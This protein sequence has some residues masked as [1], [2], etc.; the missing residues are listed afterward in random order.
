[1]EGE[2]TFGEVEGIGESRRKVDLWDV[3]R[4]GTWNVE[5]NLCKRYRGRGYRGYTGKGVQ[6]I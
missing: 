4:R 2:G 3:R 6:V 1:M 5:G